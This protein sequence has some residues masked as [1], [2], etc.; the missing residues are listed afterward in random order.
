[1]LRRPPRSTRTAHLWP[2]APLFRFQEA[3]II[4]GAI[5]PFGKLHGGIARACGII[6]EDRGIVGT[7]PV[8]A[9]RY[10]LCHQ[11]AARAAKGLRRRDAVRRQPAPHILE[12]EI[13]IDIAERVLRRARRHLNDSRTDRRREGTKWGRKG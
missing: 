7:E 1:M 11:P 13:E 2:Y 9:V 4:A 8:A 10:P 3:G 12:P 5:E 6:F